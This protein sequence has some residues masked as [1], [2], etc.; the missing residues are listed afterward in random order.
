MTTSQ[1]CFTSPQSAPT[2]AHCP[3]Y[4]F[5]GAKFCTFNAYCVFAKDSITDTSRHLDMIRFFHRNRLHVMGIQEPYL[6]TP[7][8]CA[9]AKQCFS[10]K[11][12]N[13]LSNTQYSE[14]EEQWH[15]FITRTGP[16]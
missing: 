12:I 1:T 13:F 14:P 3:P 16:W 2:P 8:D 5:S 10:D 9:K 7:D 11:G 15:S 6:Q 4:H